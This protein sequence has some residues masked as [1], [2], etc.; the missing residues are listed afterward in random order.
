MFCCIA[1]EVDHLSCCLVLSAC[2]VAP[3]PSES[4]FFLHF[5][6]SRTEDPFR[7]DHKAVSG[8]MFLS[9]CFFL[10]FLFVYVPHFSY[11]E[12]WSLLCPVD[13]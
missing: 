12:P 8:F 1:K 2:F 13:T 4:M 6:H 9:F 5:S 7:T 11:F 10:A 3:V